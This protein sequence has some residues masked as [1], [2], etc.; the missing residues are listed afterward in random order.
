MATQ[1]CRMKNGQKTF[2][3]NLTPFFEGVKNKPKHTQN[4]LKTLGNSLAH[5]RNNRVTF[6]NNFKLYPPL[7]AMADPELAEPKLSSLEVPSSES[8]VVVDP[9]VSDLTAGAPPRPRASPLPLPR[10]PPLLRG[11]EPP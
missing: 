4:L 6:T 8:L 9:E 7:A 3:N 5:F 1:L 2:Q 10:P 11:R